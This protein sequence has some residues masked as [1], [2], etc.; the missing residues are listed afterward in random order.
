L[1]FR[2][3]RHRTGSVSASS[4]TPSPDTFEKSLSES[5]A[6]GQSSTQSNNTEKQQNKKNT[7]NGK[8][9]T[10][11]QNRG[12]QEELEVQTRWRMKRNEIQTQQEEQQLNPNK[13]R[14]KPSNYA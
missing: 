1:R 10:A 4:L 14:K 9:K 6:E 3:L 12:V 13:E 5:L 7:A 2:R 8:K 11:L